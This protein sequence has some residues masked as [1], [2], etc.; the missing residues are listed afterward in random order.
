MRKLKTVIAFFNE[1]HKMEIKYLTILQQNPTNEDKNTGFL[2]ALIPL[3]DSQITSLDQTYNSGN[4]FPVVLQ[5][6]LSLAGGYCYV[7][8][9]G[10]TNDIGQLQKNAAKFLSNNNLSINTPYFAIDQY[11]GDQFLFVYLTQGITNPI[12]YQA[13][14]YVPEGENWLDSTTVTLSALINNT[15]KTFLSGYNPF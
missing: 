4:Q 6:L 2:T 3:S 1:Y 14:P 8:D 10:S 13:M 7:F 9:Y 5:E 11:G 12:V 15:M